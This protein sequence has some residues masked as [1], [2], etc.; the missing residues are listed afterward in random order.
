MYHGFYP[1][2]RSSEEAEEK[3]YSFKRHQEMPA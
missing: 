2:A 1:C 3:T